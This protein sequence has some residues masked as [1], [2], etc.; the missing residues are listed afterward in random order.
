VTRAA[1][2][3][4]VNKVKDKSDAFAWSWLKGAAT[5]GGDFGN[6]VTTD[7]VTVCVFDASGSTARLVLGAE[8]AA[9]G[10]C[11]RKPCWKGVGRPAASKGFRYSDSTGRVGGITVITLT[12]G[13]AGK[14]KIVVRGKGPGLAMPALPA[15][16]PLVVQ[17]GLSGGA[18]F[19]ARYPAP[20][21]KKNDWTRFTARNVP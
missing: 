13:I 2:V 19:E 6:P 20:G 8:V 3:S 7:A 5:L 10:T 9:S 1:S 12:P 16:V 15:P 14:A 11:R 21:V 4:L 17:L 18:C